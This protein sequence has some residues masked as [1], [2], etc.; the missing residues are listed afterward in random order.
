MLRPIV[1]PL[2]ARRR[3]PSDRLG[4]EVARG[5]LENRDARLALTRDIYIPPPEEPGLGRLEAALDRAVEALSVEAKIR[6]AVRNGRLDRSPGDELLENALTAGIN[7]AKERL[8]VLAADELRD[9]VIK[10][11]AFDPHTFENVESYV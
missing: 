8:T 3:E 9:E 1:F 6:D 10:V 7:T 4:A 5:L 2:G 11:D